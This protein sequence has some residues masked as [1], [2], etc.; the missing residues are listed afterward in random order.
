MAARA[1]W[2]GRIVL[3]KSSVGVKFYSAAVDQRVHFRLLH[4]RDK[5]PV[6]QRMV[7]PETGEAVPHEQTRLGYHA[8]DGTLVVLS[9]EELAKLDPPESRDVELTRFVPS[10]SIEPPWYVRPYLLAPDGNA[11]AY[12]AL[13]Q[14]LAA[15]GKTGIARWVM[16]KKA[17]AGAL[18][19]EDG[20]LWL[21]TL[22]HSEEVISED[23]AP[24]KAAAPNEKERHMAQQL[25]GMFTG[26]FDLTE[27]RDEYRERVLDF[28]RK[29]ARGKKP[30]L[31]KPALR[32]TQG[33]LSSALAASLKH[34]RQ[35]KVA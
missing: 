4:A 2:K 8:D 12:F 26:D 14:A 5:S 22:R 16:R 6:E 31:R 20:A 35:R 19:V 23:I 13:A 32:K 21:I 33:D 29:K 30:T 10:E 25:I 24:E 15:E 3:G 34:A 28:V 17:Y 18:R 7:N 9:R 1:I 11:E 27:Y